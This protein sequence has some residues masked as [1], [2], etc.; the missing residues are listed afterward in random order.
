VTDPR[1]GT[2]ER[3]TSSVN[4]VCL[5]IPG[6]IVAIEPGAALA[7]IDVAGVVRDINVTLVDGSLAPGE[8]VLTH[9]GFA[10]NRMT[11]QDAEET[12]ALFEELG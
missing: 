3:G 1:A 9:S 2:D 11:T 5:G 7:Q 8:Y 4:G 12:L 6:R 10:L